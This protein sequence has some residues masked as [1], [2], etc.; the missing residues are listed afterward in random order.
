[1]D[2]S[3][4]ITPQLTP[5]GGPYFRLPP[6][7]INEDAPFLALGQQI[8]W[9]ITDLGIEKIHARGITGKNIRIAVIDTGVDTEHPDLKTQILGKFNTTDEVYSSSNGHGTA[10]AGV[11]AAK[12]NGVGVLGV[13]PDAK[14]V[15]IKALQE[16]GF[17]TNEAIAKAIEVAIRQQVH[18]INLSLGSPTY[19]SPVHQAIK[20]AHRKG[21]LVVC[22]AGNDGRNNSVSYP[23]KLTETW[24]VA[25]TNDR[26]QVSAF[27]S[28]GKEVEIAAPGERILCC[29]RNGE[30]V[31]ISGTSFAAPFVS[32]VLALALEI[33][34][35]DKNFVLSSSIDI[36]T[37]GRD[38]KSG[39]G[40]INPLEFIREKT[41][42]EEEKFKKLHRIEGAI[43]LLQDFLSHNRS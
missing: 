36:E 3:N 2:A 16:R 31:S 21:I 24:A 28:R 41:E 9:G 30:Y 15:A 17:G 40:L 1:M 20:E 37:P 29:W 22:A 5:Q 19:S 8:G 6:F 4:Q 34:G 23:A 25:A 32:G 11:I 33:G 43:A 10:V 39:Y 18:I 42:C 38:M 13:A 27:S 26:R 35:V 14:I 12:H 7:V